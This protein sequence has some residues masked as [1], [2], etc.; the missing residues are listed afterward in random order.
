MGRLSDYSS[1]NPD[2]SGS[3][4]SPEAQQSQGMIS[5]LGGTRTPNLL[6]RSQML[7][8]IELR[9]QYV[10]SV[11]QPHMR[12]QRPDWLHPRISSKGGIASGAERY[13]HPSAAVMA[14]GSPAMMPST[15][16]SIHD[17]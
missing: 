7:Y 1:Y 8:P 13:R 16:S 11:G 17:R 10:S 2:S 5:A 15:P 6:I 4:D 3:D 9:A 12:A 14:A